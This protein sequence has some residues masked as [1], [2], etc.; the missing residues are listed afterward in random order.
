MINLCAENTPIYSGTSVIPN[1]FGHLKILRCSDSQNRSDNDGVHDRKSTGER[2]RQLIALSSTHRERVVC[3][4]TWINRSE[5]KRTG[6]L[7]YLGYT[8]SVTK[9][10]RGR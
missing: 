3:F 2:D 6:Y 4:S 10:Q 5:A 7:P 9:Q 1:P 8:A